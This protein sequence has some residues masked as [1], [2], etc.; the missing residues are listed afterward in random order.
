[1]STNMDLSN[2][3]MDLSNGPLRQG[4]RGHRP[5][6][7]LSWHRIQPP[8]RRGVLQGGAGRGLSERTRSDGTE[9]PGTISLPRSPMRRRTPR[10]RTPLTSRPPPGG[11]RAGGVRRRA[12]ARAGGV[13]TQGRGQRRSPRARRWQINLV[14]LDERC[15]VVCRTRITMQFPAEFHLRPAPDNLTNL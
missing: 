10:R 5:S 13:P 2:P 1:M 4:N 9:S 8:Y 14:V 3:N 12:G 11:P 6:G 7:M 15:A